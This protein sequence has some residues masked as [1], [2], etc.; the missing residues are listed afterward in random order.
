MWVISA[1]LLVDDGVGLDVLE[2]L[3]EGMDVNHVVVGGELCL[4]LVDLQRT[5]CCLS[6]L[7]IC[8]LA[9]CRLLA[10]VPPR[11]PCTAAV[12]VQFVA[13]NPST[14]TAACCWATASLAC[15]MPGYAGRLTS[16][17]GRRQLF[18]PHAVELSPV[19][20]SKPNQGL[21][22]LLMCRHVCSA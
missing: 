10:V 14:G 2:S 8:L 21:Q 1:P 6:P 3:V 22:D 12:V 7:V 9:H 4:L 18:L 19:W 13:A 16:Y 20:T 5:C 15:E 17:P 11:V